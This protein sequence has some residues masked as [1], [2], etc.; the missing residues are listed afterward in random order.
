MQLTLQHRDASHQ[1]VSVGVLEAG[2]QEPAGQ[3]DHLRLRSRQGPEVVVLARG[4]DPAV[5]HGDATGSRALEARGEQAAADE[6]GVS[7]GIRAVHV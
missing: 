2:E 7:Q 3:I 5:A 4:Q 6:Q 1:G